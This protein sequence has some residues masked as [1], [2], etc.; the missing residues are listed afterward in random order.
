MKVR[1]AE[2]PGIGKKISFIT[3]ENSM[4]VI[5]I[6]HTGRRDLY[7][8][9]DSDNDEADF[10][11]NLS[12]EETRELGAQL[13][14]ALYQPVDL[15]RLEFFRKQIRI[16]W[17]EVHPE[18]SLAGKSIAESRIRSRTGATIIGIVKEDEVQAV[19]DIDI[20]LQPGDTLMVLGKRDQ[21]RELEELCCKE[22]S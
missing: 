14:G 12:S 5:I 15:D 22:S 10:S 20:L 6:H 8:F 21:V 9:E 3:A 7:F 11:I 18:S 2:L 4:I 17:L 13:L 19:P 1:S 16:E